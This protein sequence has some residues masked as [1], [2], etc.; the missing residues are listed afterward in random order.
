MNTDPSATPSSVS[1]LSA[2]HDQEA[3]LKR[4]KQHIEQQGGWLS[5]EAYMQ[6]VLYEPPWGYYVNAKRKIGF[7]PQDGSDF[8]TAPEL[9]SGFGAMWAEQIQRWMDD[10]GLDE[11]WEFG[12]GRGTLAKDILAHLDTK[13]YSFKSG[14]LKKYHIIEVSAS[15]KQE[16]QT[17]LQPWLSHINW[18]SQWPDDF[19]G[20][21]IANEVLDAMPVKLLYREKNQW[22]ERGLVFNEHS[23]CLEWKDQ[24][25][26]HR[27]PHEP[28]GDHPYLTELHVQACAWI[29]SLGER[30]KKGV[31]LLADYGFPAHEYFHEERHMGTLMCHQSH[32]SDSN[33][34]IDL[35]QK[36]I[37]SHIDFTAIALA[38][39][40][41]GLDIVGYTSQGRF[42]L[43]CGL[44]QW[45]EN[46]SLAVRAQSSLLIHEHEMG[47]LFKVMALASRAI[48]PSLN[49]LGFEPGDRT[50]RL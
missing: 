45:M 18:Q 33:P 36:D 24:A 46:Q 26:S 34:L 39:Q 7:S 10:T 50:H 41:V 6:I 42:L 5:F 44:A 12:A 48:A 30:L 29:K 47:E 11:I 4:I 15:L 3:L 17:L 13:G 32:Q 27:P 20:L 38:A 43:N 25:S 8:V 37:T 16:Q 23:A 2:S 22:Y 19:C 35:G 31:V 1:S 40:E 28:T 9:S 21:V 49:A 14:R